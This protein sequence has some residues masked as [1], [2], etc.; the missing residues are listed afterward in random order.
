MPRNSIF[1]HSMVNEDARS[2]E[3]QMSDLGVEVVKQKPDHLKSIKWVSG[4]SK[5]NHLIDKVC[6][7]KSSV[8]FG[9]EVLGILFDDSNNKKIQ[10]ATAEL[11][12]QKVLVIKTSKT[13]YVVVQG[14][15]GRARAGSSRVMQK[16]REHGLTL[17]VYRV[18]KARGGI[19]CIPEG[20]QI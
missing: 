8:S 15:T 7:N 10:F 5:V 4:W 1:D 6:I 17:G 11:R 12:G 9:D 13:G 3:Q 2:F 18:K 16:L 19:I 20:R 14:K